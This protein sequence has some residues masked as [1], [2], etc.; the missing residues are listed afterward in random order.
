M[1]YAVRLAITLC[2]LG[3]LLVWARPGHAQVVVLPE[4]MPSS[5]APLAGF[6]PFA[7]PAQPAAGGSNLAGGCQIVGG[8]ACGGEMLGGDIYQGPAF[9]DAFPE[10]YLPQGPW[11]VETLPDSVIYHSYLAGAK[12]PR[13]AGL[14][15]YDQGR[16]WFLDGTLGARVGLLRYGTSDVFLPQGFEVDVEGA[17]FPRVNFTDQWDLESADFRIGVPFTWGI[18][19][20]QMKVEFYH[21]S[22]HVGDLYLLAHPDFVRINYSRNAF[23]W[24]HSYYLTDDWRIYGEAEWASYTDGGSKP[25]EFQTG[26]EYSPLHPWGKFGGAPFFAFNAASRQ[27]VGYKGNIVVQGGWQWRGP[28]S[29]HLFR[30]GVEYYNGKSDQYEFYT[31]TDQYVA[32]GIWYDF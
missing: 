32:G 7:G 14:A 30:M 17:A 12:E 6:D 16:G 11:T 24:G 15:A 4:Q 26:F 10:G 13:M 2:A 23:V 1:P 21:L 29:N 9:P 31:R 25:W 5:G 18:G 22:A 28:R 8:N 27:E 20:Y 3:L 19:R